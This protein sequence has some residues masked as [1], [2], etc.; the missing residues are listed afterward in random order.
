MKLIFKGKKVRENQAPPEE[1]K[2][3]DKEMEVNENAVFKTETGE[4]IPVSEMVNAYKAMK[5]NI[6]G[7]EEEKAIGMEDTVEIDGEQVSMKDLYENWASR[8][9][10]EPPTDE[11]LE[12]VVE[13]DMK[14]NSLGDD[15]GDRKTKGKNFKLLQNAAERESDPGKPRIE[16]ER[17]RIDRGKNRYGT[18]VHNGGDK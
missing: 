13:E 9:N 3:P 5:E 14:K 15:D 10:A 18:P 17:A 16:T 11:P 4:E 8:Q 2:E 12:P 1:K 7:A 6:E